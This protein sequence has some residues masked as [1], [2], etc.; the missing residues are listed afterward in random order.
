MRAEE[1]IR[2]DDTI[3]S[4]YTRLKDKEHLILPEAIDLFCRDKLF[5]KNSMVQILDKRFLKHKGIVVHKTQRKLKVLIIGS[6]GREHSLAWKIK[7]SP[8]V[9]EIFQ[10]RE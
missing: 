2:Q 10:A 1:E 8:I 9:S 6:G 7:K 4:Y 3:D 5:I